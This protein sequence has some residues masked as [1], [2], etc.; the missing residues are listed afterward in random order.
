MNSACIT[1]ESR[2]K[3]ERKIRNNKKTLQ[4]LRL[5]KGRIG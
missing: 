1:S 4:M 2:E 3:A 5:K